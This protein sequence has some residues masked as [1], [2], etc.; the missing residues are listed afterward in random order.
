MERYIEFYLSHMRIE[1]EEVIPLAVKNLTAQDWAELDTAFLANR[2][3]LTGQYP[4]D[5]AYDRLFTR[6]VM[7]VKSPLGQG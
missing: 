4:V 1:E 7:R 2:D 5:P 3:P 6:I